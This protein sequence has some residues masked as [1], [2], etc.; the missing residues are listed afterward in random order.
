MRPI[1]WIFDNLQI[2]ALV[3]AGIVSLLARRKKAAEAEEVEQHMP[4]PIPVDDSE[5]ERSIREDIARRRAERE[6]RVLTPQTTLRPDSP[7]VDED[8][9]NA[10]GLDEWAEPEPAPV[11][12]PSRRA[13]LDRE[14]TE[15]A[16]ARQLELQEKM[17]ALEKARAEARAEAKAVS[18]AAYQTASVTSV[19]RAPVRSLLAGLKS[20][21]EARRAILYA[22]IMGQPKSLGS[23]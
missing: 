6:G 19:H 1:D 9:D 16:L 4:P 3:A 14:E 22:E 23:R 7:A 12:A 21:E 13:D 20:P 11:A 17:A 8:R 15:A 10:P 2:I 18:A 5:L